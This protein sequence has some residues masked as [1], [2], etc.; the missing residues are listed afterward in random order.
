MKAFEFREMAKEELERKVHDLEEEQFRMR[1]SAG[2]GAE[3]NPA[4][5]RKIRRDLA[6]ARTVL[7]EREMEGRES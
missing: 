7:R 4:S 6:R 1:F 2:R 5:K 3:A